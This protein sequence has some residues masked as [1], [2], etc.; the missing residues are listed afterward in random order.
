MN[1]EAVVVVGCY[2]LLFSLNHTYF[3]LFPALFLARIL[4]TS[5][6]EAF[7]SST[8]LWEDFSPAKP[9]FYTDFSPGFHKILTEGTRALDTPPRYAPV[10]NIFSYFYYLSRDIINERSRGKAL[11]KRRTRFFWFLIFFLT[12]YWFFCFFCCFFSTK[13]T[14]FFLVI[15]PIWSVSYFNVVFQE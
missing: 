14:W 10:S 15:Y 1:I 7:I 9:G 5:F 11:E 3:R 13:C 6:N 2:C 4:Y 8:K 12:F